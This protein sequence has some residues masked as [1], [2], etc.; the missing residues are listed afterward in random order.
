MLIL[1][2]NPF[3]VEVMGLRRKRAQKRGYQQQKDESRYLREYY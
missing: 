3:P 1:S 2:E